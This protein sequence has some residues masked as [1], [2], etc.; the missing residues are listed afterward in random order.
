M[1]I[2][3]IPLFLIVVICGAGIFKAMQI[4][5]MPLISILFLVVGVIS[6]ILFF[7]FKG[8]K[9]NERK[10]KIICF[11]IAVLFIII[12]L[13]TLGHSVTTENIFSWIWHHI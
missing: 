9:Q 2:V 3:S 8:K 1:L 10:A 13:C 7:K 5:I 6:F 12:F 11:I 4:N